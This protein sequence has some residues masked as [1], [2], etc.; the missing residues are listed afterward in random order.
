M[1]P[2]REIE[3]LIYRYAE[4]IDAGD[5]PAIGKLLARACFVGPEGDVQ[6]QGGEAIAAIYS[7]FTRIY[8]DGTPL[9]HHITSNVLV[10]VDG[11]SATARS[12]FTVLQATDGLPLQ[13][14]MAGR[15]V[16]AFACDDDGWYF[17]SRQILPRLSGD[18]SQH[19]LAGL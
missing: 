1:S 9:S 8:P 5:I 4:L 19:L 2:E 14:V 11:D 6:A 16:D 3:N 10:Q 13:P 18:L 7:A 15:Y 17:A 12:Y